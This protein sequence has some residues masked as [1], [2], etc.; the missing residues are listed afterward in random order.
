MT[1]PG[2]SRTFA[3]IFTKL[4]DIRDH[5]FYMDNT[6]A[7]RIFFSF[8]SPMYLEVHNN[9]GAYAGADFG[10]PSDPNHGIRW[11]L[12]EFTNGNNGIWINTSRVDAFQYPMGLELY[13]TNNASVKYI[14][15]GE[16]K[17]YGDIIARWKQQHGSDIYS[18]CL[19]NDITTD[20]KGGI[21]LQP[22][23]VPAVKNSGFFDDYINRVWDY[24]RNHTMSVKLGVLGEFK[25]KVEGNEF[26]LY[27]QQ[28][29]Y[30]D[31]QSGE[32][33]IIG[34]PTTTDA[35]E[36][37][38]TFAFPN[39]KI[40]MPVQAMFCGAFNRGAIRLTEDHQDWSPE[41]STYFSGE[42]P[43]NEYVKFFH[44]NDITFE[45][46]TYAFAYDDTYD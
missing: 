8:R 3:S 21:I 35:V 39:T 11:E 42:Y 10:N 31:W 18:N 12:V 14:K 38:G 30:G 28:S 40:S 19:L 6:F 43:C 22:S 29:T 33:A 41:G 20:N 23:K 9:E 16:I 44:Q 7:C 34:K 27:C 25:G 37:A 45:S 32:V 13:G 36:G 46:R 17:S 1:K 4:S 15:T 24:Y 5:T 26:K 2:E